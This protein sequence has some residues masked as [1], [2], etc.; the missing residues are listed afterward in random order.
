MPRPHLSSTTLQSID[1]A[2]YVVNVYA[3]TSKDSK[4][5]YELKECT[6]NRLLMWRYAN[7]IGYHSIGKKHATLIRVQK[8]SFHQ[9]T[10]TSD[11]KSL[12]PLGAFDHS[13]K[14][15]KVNDLSLQDAILILERFLA[16]K[17]NSMQDIVNS[18]LYTGTDHHIYLELKP[19]KKA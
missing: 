13:I 3:K 15:E 14:N 1:R 11:L 16:R 18:M 9:P 7:R 4:I 2:L 10:K 17:T 12:T 8:R 6:L 19:S 5:L